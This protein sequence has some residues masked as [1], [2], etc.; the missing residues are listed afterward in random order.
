MSNRENI[1]NEL[2]FYINSLCEYKQAIESN[3]EERLIA[4]LDEGR[5]RKEEVDG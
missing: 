3:N 2:D 4:I 5:K 1:L